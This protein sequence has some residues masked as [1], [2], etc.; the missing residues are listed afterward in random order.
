MAP[1]PNVNVE[2]AVSSVPTASAVVSIS[3][4][5]NDVDKKEAERVFAKENGFNLVDI[6]REK[7]R[8]LERILKY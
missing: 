4:N 3:D 5:N 6:D 1:L 8:I 2:A 7:K